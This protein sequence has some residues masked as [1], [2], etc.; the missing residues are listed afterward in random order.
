VD[1]D[2]PIPDRFH[3]LVETA[4][5]LIADG[6]RE[7]LAANERVIFLAEDPLLWLRVDAVELVPLPSEAW[8]SSMAGPVDRRPGTWW[9]AVDLWGPDGPTDYTLEGTAVEGPDGIR[10]TVSDIHVM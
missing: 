7:A 10:L 8:A 9:L 5:A 2:C 4:V 1:E 3:A 6:R